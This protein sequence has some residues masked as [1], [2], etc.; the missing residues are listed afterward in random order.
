VCRQHGQTDKQHAD[1]GGQGSRTDAHEGHLAPAHAAQPS[2]LE[3][4]I[5]KAPDTAKIVQKLVGPRDQEQVHLAQPCATQHDEAAFSDQCPGERGEE[6]QR[7]DRSTETRDVLDPCLEAGG[8]SCGGRAAGLGRHPALCPSPFV[9]D[10]LGTSGQGK[11]GHPMPPG[12]VGRVHGEANHL[13]IGNAP[14]QIFD[15]SLDNGLV[16]QVVIAV[17]AQNTDAKT[18]GCLVV[19]SRMGA[20]ETGA[21]GMA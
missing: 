8:G 13:R 7:P 3:H 17:V 12:G 2:P 5:R 21:K 20:H 18:A 11:G 19:R 15:H 6:A 1:R 9:G 16:T 10:G 4:R 14:P